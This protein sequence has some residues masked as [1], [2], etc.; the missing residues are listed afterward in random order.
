MNVALISAGY[1]PDLDGIGDYTARLGEVLAQRNEIARPVTVFTRYG[2]SASTEGIQVIPFFDQRSPWTFATLEQTFASAFPDVET[3]VPDWLVL[4]YNPFS[5]GRRGFCPWVPRTLARIKRRTTAQ[6]AV[7]FHETTVPRWP[8]KFAAMFLWQWPIFRALCRLAD[9]GFISTERWRAQTSRANPL[10][11][12]H[13]LP[14]GSNIPV[15]KLSREAA[16]AQLGVESEALVLGVFGSAHVSR[17]LDWI[18][19]AIREAQQRN[20]GRRTLLL[21]VGPHGARVRNVCE[22][23]EI[24][25][26]GP[27][28]GE[29]VGCRLRAMDAILSPFLDGISTRR[30]SVIAAL[31]HGVPVA[32]SAAPWTDR[33]FLE[34]PTQGLLLS[35]AE[36]AQDFAREAGNWLERIP[37]DFAR[38]ENAVSVFHD[39]HF[40]WPAIAEGLWTNLARHSLGRE[41]R[42]GGRTRTI[43]A[44]VPALFP[45]PRKFSRTEARGGPAP[46]DRP[47]PAS[48]TFIV[49]T[50]KRPDYL[51]K[52]LAS[53]EAQTVRAGR[54]LVGVKQEDGFSRAVVDEFVA[55][56]QVRIIEARGVGVVGSMSSCL[57]EADGDFVALVDDDVELPSAWLGT[58][59]EHL[60]CNPDIVAAAGR[61]FLQD[62]PKMRQFESRVMNVGR[63]YWYGRITGEHHRG[64]GTP[65]KVDVLRGSNCLFRG[66]FLRETGFEPGLRGQGAQVN[67]ELALAFHAMRKGAHF[68]YDPTVEVLHHAAPRH[69]GDS[70]HR[71]TFNPLG[72]LHSAFNETFVTVR[73]APGL[74]KLTALSYQLMVGSSLAPGLF[75]FLKDVFKRDPDQV[76]RWIAT[77]RG[78]WE[79]ALAA[80]FT[81][82]AQIKT[83]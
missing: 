82:S 47:Q 45:A 59:L 19:C 5:F 9:A 39:R 83:P 46:S 22:G 37:A 30:G 65:R 34:A 68:L 21:Y 36:N 55:R 50:L 76:A 4:Q 67:W 64:A 54:V 2:T 49:P 32:T 10:L 58:M 24:L 80:T 26:A 71:G 41:A 43:S 20:R 75:H 15:C 53:I 62:H 60:E 52:C 63:I 78:R 23:V 8:L 56:V 12:V 44:K 73:H 35:T 48:V 38:P 33:L 61:D 51:R 1:P 77:L 40:A 70:I 28:P 25:D 74:H 11:P 29:E 27:L 31:Q 14:V 13:H 42:V 7:M 81:Q 66:A 6:I 16:R 17:R 79:A 18:A 57:Q 69:D 3:P 72:T